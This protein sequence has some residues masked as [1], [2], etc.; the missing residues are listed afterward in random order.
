MRKQDHLTALIHSLSQGERK[1]FSQ[2]SRTAEGGKSYLKLYELLLK[3]STYDAEA[4]CKLLNKSKTV[5]AN[6]KKYLEKNLLSALREYHEAHPQVSILNRIAES[7]LLMERNMPGL[8]TS[9]AKSSIKASAALGLHPLEWHAHGLM[10][11]LC[12]DPFVSFSVSEQTADYHL[13]KMKALAIQIR[14]ATDFEILNTEVFAA[15]EKRKID[16]TDAH[17]KETQKL[18]KHKLLNTDYDSFIFSSYKYS[19][20]SLLYARIGN[21]QANIEANKQLLMK[22]E[23]QASIDVIGYWNT[24]ANLTQSIVAGGSKQQYETWISKLQSKHYHKLPVDAAYIDKMLTKHKNIFQSGATFRQLMTNEITQE[25]TRKF[26]KKFLKS[27]A[28]EKRNTPGF[29]YTSTVYKT[30]ACCF[31]IGDM[32][33]CIDLLNKLL[34][35]TDES[36]NLNAYKNARMLFVMAHAQQQNYQLLPSLIQSVENY[37]RKAG[38]AHSTE[39]VILKHLL[40]LAKTNNIKARKKWFTNFKETLQQLITQPEANKAIEAL[41]LQQWVAM[42]L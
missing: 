24:I 38:I 6:E 34:N 25:E 36:L 9:A 15:Y 35:E 7:V 32:D 33:D 3:K 20:Q 23:Q 5:L 30:A 29:H 19:L 1:Y 21:T 37:F 40:E 12:S 17:R 26:T 16:I 13:A 28:Q 10:L 31:I 39:Q 14:L 8:A 22:Y 11:T 27:V 2:R 4:L 42:N 18:L 41:P